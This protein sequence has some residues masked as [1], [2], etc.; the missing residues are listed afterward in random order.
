MA[1]PPRSSI[2]CAIWLNVAAACILGLSVQA[3]LSESDFK[4]ADAALNTAYQECLRVFPRR[5][6]ERLR[7]AQRAWIT[8]TEKDE[9]AE[10][11]IGARA[12]IARDDLDRDALAEVAA[13]TEQL[14]SFFVLPNQDIKSCRD[15]WQKAERELTIAYQT[16]MAGARRA[17]E[18]KRRGTRLDRLQREKFTGSFWRSQWT[19]TDLG[20]NRRGQ[21]TD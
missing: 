7:V 6:K 20:S 10:A 14:K 11:F 9:T 13:R 15:E 5:S 3:E 19:C 16:A 18:V 21:A 17:S 12:A 2:L 8:F 4:E 1:S